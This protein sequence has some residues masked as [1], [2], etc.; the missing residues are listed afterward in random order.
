MSTSSLRAR[1]RKP[2]KSLKASASAWP[3]LKA[4]EKL[5]LAGSITFST[6]SCLGSPVSEAPD[7]SKMT[8]QSQERR[9]SVKNFSTA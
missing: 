1:S 8:V 9:G 4:R 7:A 5:G 6:T 2:V 3:G